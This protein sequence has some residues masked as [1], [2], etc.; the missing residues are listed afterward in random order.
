M[1]DSLMQLLP[2]NM[3][4][5]EKTK[6][7]AGLKKILVTYKDNDKRMKAAYALGRISGDAAESAEA[8]LVDFARNESNGEPMRIH[9]ILSLGKQ[10]TET[11]EDALISFLSDSSED[12]R[13]EALKSLSDFDTVKT[14]SAYAA[15]LNDPAPKIIDAIADSLGIS[16]Q[17]ASSIKEAFYNESEQARLRACREINSA[18]SR[19]IIDFLIKVCN[20][21]DDKIKRR[22][23][24]ALGSIEFEAVI[25]P[26]M[27]VIDKEKGENLA[28]AYT[29]LGKVKTEKTVD[30]LLKGLDNPSSLVKSSCIAAL[31]DKKSEKAVPKL[32]GIFADEDTDID[33]RISIAKALGKTKSY[34]A[35]QTMLDCIK[36][37]PDALRT[38]IE[39]AL[40]EMN[41]KD[42]PDTARPMLEGGTDRER[43]S[44]VKILT[45][46]RKPGVSEILLPM[47]RD[48]LPDLKN[49]LIIG[50]GEFKEPSVAAT[51]VDFASDPAVSSQLR[52][53]A[54]R[55]IGNIADENSR[56]DLFEFLKNDDEYIRSSAAFALGNYKGEA[57][58][59]ILGSALNDP[60]ELVRVYAV[61][62]LG[63]MKDP[64]TLEYLRKA[65]ND[66]SDK[67][68]AAVVRVM[69][70][71]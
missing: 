11:S 65:K 14:A 17:A 41:H 21:T 44:C 15:S 24:I 60:S 20:G 2:V 51:L 54:I 62:S 66:T 71:M 7:V 68:K 34:E 55:S 19:K 4:K 58:I 63:Q 32:L 31:C 18:K 23:L 10:Q 8:V 39:D 37:A 9:C 27:A 22:A 12:I 69:R 5:L 50:L 43:L 46:I 16:V 38:K 1:F 64:N 56:Y 61:E 33:Y 45:K 35:M 48:R 26:I 6:D 28:A 70:N 67:V 52:S 40:V 36:N 29:A 53:Q 59:E 13:A 57:V 47:L 3:D 25:A 42:L 30:V 49:I